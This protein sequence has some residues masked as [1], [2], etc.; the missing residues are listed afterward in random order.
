[1]IVI[2]IAAG[3]ILAALFLAFLPWIL[4]GLSFALGGAVLLAII[5]GVVW[6]VWTGTQSAEGIAAELIISGVFLSLFL[7]WLVYEIK[8]R[9]EI[10]AE[11]TKAALARAWHDGE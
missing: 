6:V 10:K 9:R 5:G 3:I 2:E 7:P 11:Q 1:M 4:V 8:A